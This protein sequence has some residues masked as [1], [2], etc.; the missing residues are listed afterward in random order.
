MRRHHPG[1]VTWV[2]IEAEAALSEIDEYP[3]DPE[4]VSLAR[5]VG[6]DGLRSLDAIHLASAVLADADL[7]LT[8]DERMAVACAEF[9]LAVARPS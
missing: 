6:P 7:V 8:Y 9:G 3:I 1:R 2:S 4:V 5:R